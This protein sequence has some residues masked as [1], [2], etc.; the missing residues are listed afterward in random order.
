MICRPNIVISIGQSRQNWL[1]HSPS[2]WDDY[3]LGC[4]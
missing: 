2:T 4:L 1:R 3:N